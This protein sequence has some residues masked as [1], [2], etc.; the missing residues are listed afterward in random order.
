MVY[1][2]PERSAAIPRILSLMTAQ[3]KFRETSPTCAE[4]T[5]EQ[6]QIRITTGHSLILV[7]SSY[8]SI[9]VSAVGG[10]KVNDFTIHG[11]F[12]GRSDGDKG[13]TNRILLQLAAGLFARGRRRTRRYAGHLRKSPHDEH[14]H[15]PDENSSD[16]NDN[17]PKHVSEHGKGL[18]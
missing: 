2:V 4:L 9:F 10:T 13:S 3:P 15:M 16:K 17:Q 8:S 18:G 6:T 1:C 7:G 5:A 14:N 12:D 11:L